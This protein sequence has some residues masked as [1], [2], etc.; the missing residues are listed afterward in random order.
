MMRTKLHVDRPGHSNH[1]RCQ[2]CQP[3]DGIYLTVNIEDSIKKKM[4]Q[5]FVVVA[6]CILSSSM[7][8]LNKLESDEHSAVY[9]LVGVA[10]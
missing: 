10:M 8:I 9:D 1:C 2:L 4:Q 3:L 5:T 6:Y 7:I